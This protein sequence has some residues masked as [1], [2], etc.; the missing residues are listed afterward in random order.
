MTCGVEFAV[1][2]QSGLELGTCGFAVAAQVGDF[3]PGGGFGA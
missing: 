1:A 3:G 2:L